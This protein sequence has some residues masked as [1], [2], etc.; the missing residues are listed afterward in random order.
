MTDTVPVLFHWVSVMPDTRQYKQNGTVLESVNT[1]VL[2]NV[3]N[4]DEYVDYKDDGLTILTPAGMRYCI[5]Q[6]E[7]AFADDEVKPKDFKS[8]NNEEWEESLDE[9]VPA[10]KVDDV[11]WTDDNAEWEDA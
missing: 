4:T 5:N 7:A 9:T 6:L 8:S 1:K 10:G 11:P 2:V 3:P